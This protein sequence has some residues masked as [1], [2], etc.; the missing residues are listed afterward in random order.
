MFD[1][2]TKKL[3]FKLNDKNLKIVE[4]IPGYQ[5]YIKNV[6]NCDLIVCYGVMKYLMLRNPIHLK[7]EKIESYNN[8]RIS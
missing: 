5:H 1:I 2:S 8:F 6:G 7:Y 3:S 4:S